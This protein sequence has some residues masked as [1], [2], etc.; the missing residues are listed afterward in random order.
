MALARRVLEGVDIGARECGWQAEATI[1]ADSS[2]FVASQHS[3]KNF[4]K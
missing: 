3:M 2:I 1:I 4:L